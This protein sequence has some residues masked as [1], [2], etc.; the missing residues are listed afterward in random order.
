MFIRLATV[1]QEVSDSVRFL[2]NFATLA[3]FQSI[4]QKIEVIFSTWQNVTLLWSFIYANGANFHHCKWPNI[5]INHFFIWSHC[6]L[7][8]ASEY[9]L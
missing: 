4:W 2:Q 5:E 3:K 7:P 1:D 9:S 8:Q 6:N